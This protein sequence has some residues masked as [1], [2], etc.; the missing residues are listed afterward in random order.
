MAAMPSVDTRFKPGEARLYDRVCATCSIEF[1]GSNRALHCDD[2][3]P[4]TV[5]GFRA[6][7]PTDVRCPECSEMRQ[8]KAASL[9]KRDGYQVAA[10]GVFERRCLSCVKG[11]PVR[12]TSK[13]SLLRLRDREWMAAAYAEYSSIDIGKQLGCGYSTV[14]QW[15]RRHGIEARSRSEAGRKRYGSH[16]DR[17]KG[18][19][20]Q[21]VTG[22]QSDVKVRVTQKDWIGG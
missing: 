13:E 8:V 5:N 18:R 19:N 14:C 10:D 22:G 3:V 7:A 16:A 17:S 6:N 4:R 12:R 21:M 15:L 1:R 11:V 20:R 2:C 9:G